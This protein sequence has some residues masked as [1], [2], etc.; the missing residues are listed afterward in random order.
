MR[1]PTIYYLLLTT[2]ILSGC[3]MRVTPRE[4]DRVDQ[5]L[6][7][8]RGMVRG[9]EAVIKEVERKRTK[10]IYDV[11]IEFG[12]SADSRRDVYTEGNKGYITKSRIPEKGAKPIK[13]K[14]PARTPQ[15]L[16][17]LETPQ[18]VFQKPT[19][20][21]EKYAKE[22]GGETLREGEVAQRIYVVKK[23]DTLQKISNKMYG[24]TRR[25]KEIYEANKD[26]LESPDL[27]KPG[28]K[29]VIPLD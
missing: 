13:K 16:V 7:G 29:L 17:P 22:K 20:P 26:I 2:L 5:E 6:K 28:Q 14:K 21:E 9:R 19:G 10:T 3:V 1:K 25:W 12:P 8:N 18:V 24:T 15:I 23:G 11:E 27:L 4:V